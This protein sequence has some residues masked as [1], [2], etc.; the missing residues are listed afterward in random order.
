MEKC[1][2]EGPHTLRELRCNSRSSESVLL[3]TSEIPRCAH[4]L[5]CYL[6]CAWA[7]ADEV[8]AAREERGDECDVDYSRDG[9]DKPALVLAKPASL[10]TRSSH[11]TV[12]V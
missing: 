3:E 5:Y 11:S 9:R 4:A 1:S 6:V 12:R 10:F 2:E 8:T 7:R